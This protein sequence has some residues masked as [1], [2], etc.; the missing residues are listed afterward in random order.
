MHTYHSSG[1]HCSRIEPGSHGQADASWREG[2][3]GRRRGASFQGYQE[4]TRG[5]ALGLRDPVI[6]LQWLVIA[7]T[8]TQDEDGPGLRADTGYA[9]TCC[10][11]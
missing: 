6:A 3:C 7:H 10:F 9:L 8:R 2:S 4:R 5:R 1:L 11:W